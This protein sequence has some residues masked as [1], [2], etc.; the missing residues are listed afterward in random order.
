MTKEDATLEDVVVG[1]V[2][3]DKNE[4]RVHVV[5]V[6]DRP[7]RRGASSSSR[8]RRRTSRVDMIVQN[9]TTDGETR[10]PTSRSPLP[11]TDLARAK[12]FIEEIAKGARRARG[13]L[14]RGRREGLD[15][16]ARHA[17]ARRASRRRCSGSSPTRG[18]TSRRSRR[19]RSRV[20]CLVAAKYTELAVRALHDGF[21]LGRRRVAK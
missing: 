15:R 20:S 19:A 17:L 18:S 3:Y 4:A 9:V 5:G 7:G 2:A 21:G 6:D 8:S 14:R 13:P 16:R 12:P 1:G 10:A 11:K